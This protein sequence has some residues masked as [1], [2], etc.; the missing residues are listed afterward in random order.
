VNL[1]IQNDESLKYKV[2]TRGNYYCTR[3]I[4]AQKNRSFRD[5]YYQD[6]L[7]VCLIWICP[8]A[9]SGQNSVASYDIQENVVIITVEKRTE[10]SG[11]FIAETRRRINHGTGKRIE[12]I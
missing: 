11:I 2:V 5:M 6:I 9:R 7:K 1:E 3:M 8:Y 4:S 10:T 12:K